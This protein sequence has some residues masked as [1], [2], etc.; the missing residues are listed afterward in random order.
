[1]G[2]RTERERAVAHAPPRSGCGRMTGAGAAALASVW[3]WLSVSV[4]G[5]GANVR[6]V[7]VGAAAGAVVVLEAALLG[8]TVAGLMAVSGLA[9][10]AATHSAWVRA[11]RARSRSASEVNA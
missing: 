8:G 10:G 9:G 7:A 4:L 5:H 2:A 3:G 11:L 1:M 6:S